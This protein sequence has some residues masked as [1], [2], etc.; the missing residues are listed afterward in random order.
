MALQALHEMYWPGDGVVNEVVV[1]SVYPHWQVVVLYSTLGFIPF[2]LP[3]WFRNR[4]ETLW[5]WIYRHVPE[6]FYLLLRLWQLCHGPQWD[7]ARQ[8]VRM[9]A[10]TP[11]MSDK[12]A[13]GEIGWRAGQNPNV[14]QNVMRLLHGIDLAG[15]GI[16][17]R[18][19][20][21]NVRLELAWLAYKDRHR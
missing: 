8:A 5:A 6:R 13:W 15:G 16:H 14:G 17:K 21:L 4:L 10:Q 19:N 20:E 3:R 11:G 12:R 18:R 7:M 1:A 9:V 2:T